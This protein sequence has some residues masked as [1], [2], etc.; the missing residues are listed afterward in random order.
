MSPVSMLT[1]SE[2][3]WPAR[4]GGFRGI[5]GNMVQSKATINMRLI[6]STT[7]ERVI[8]MALGLLLTGIGLDTVSGQLRMT[9]GLS[10]L[11]RGIKGIGP[12][13]SRTLLAE[14]P[15]GCCRAGIQSQFRAN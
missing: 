2:M 3:S 13:V 1:F 12:V 7:A 15:A 14:L 6:D 4:V 5:G 11:L 8:S 9:F 10:E